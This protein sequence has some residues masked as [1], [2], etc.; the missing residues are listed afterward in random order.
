MVYCICTQSQKHWNT[1]GSYFGRNF[2]IHIRAIWLV[3]RFSQHFDAEQKMA[4]KLKIKNSFSRQ[5]PSQALFYNIYWLLLDRT[6][7]QPLSL[8]VS[9]S[10]RLLF[11]C[12]LAIFFTFVCNTDLNAIFHFQLFIPFFSRF[13]VMRWASEQNQWSYSPKRQTHTPFIC[14]CTMQMIAMWGNLR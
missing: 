11:G 9:L 10:T 13:S 8:S 4:N 5:L 12:S 1:S 14:Y 2:P 7:T 6:L 3:V